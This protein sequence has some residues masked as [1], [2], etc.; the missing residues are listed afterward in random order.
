M[1]VT[2]RIV[3]IDED[4]VHGFA[5]EFEATAEEVLVH[6]DDQQIVVPT[7]ILQLQDDKTYHLPLQLAALAHKAD[8]PTVIS[9]LEEELSVKKRQVETGRVRIKKVVNTHEEVVDEPLLSKQVEV[10]RVPVNRPLD[11]PASVRFEGETMIVPLMEEVLV[12]KKQ[13]MLVEEVHIV[14]QKRETRDPQTIT[15]RS[16]E[17]YIEREAVEEDRND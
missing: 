12:V 11:A 2:R 16:E 7:R 9:L 15:L 8:A 10:K 6:F 17:V 14:K 5:D 13:L 3:I 4:G 1:S